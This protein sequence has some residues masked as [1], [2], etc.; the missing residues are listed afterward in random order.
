ML[1]GRLAAMVETL[2]TD[3][4]ER[5]ENFSSSI[6]TLTARVVAVEKKMEDTKQVITVELE[7]T[8]TLLKRQVAETQVRAAVVAVAIVV[9]RCCVR[10]RHSRE[11][12]CVL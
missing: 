9:D 3:I 5:F 10:C 8:G 1:E 12:Q 4:R 7:Q 2:Q 11:S 6:E